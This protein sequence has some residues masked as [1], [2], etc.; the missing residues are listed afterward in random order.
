MDSTLESVLVE[1]VSKSLMVRKGWNA[2]YL[3]RKCRICWE[4]GCGVQ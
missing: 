3:L 4:T 2:F 1:P